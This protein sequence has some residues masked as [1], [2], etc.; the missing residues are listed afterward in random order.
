MLDVVIRSDNEPAV[1][2]LSTE[3]LNVD[4]NFLARLKEAYSPCNYFS[5]ENIV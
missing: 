2:A 3:E 5:D 1:L 4:V